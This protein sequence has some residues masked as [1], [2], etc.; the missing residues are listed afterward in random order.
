MQAPKENC[1]ECGEEF[2]LTSTQSHRELCSIQNQVETTKV[3]IGI[4]WNL[5]SSLE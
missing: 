2:A 1:L 5:K 4:M 3:H